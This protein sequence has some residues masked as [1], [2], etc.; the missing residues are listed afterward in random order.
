MGLT[1]QP[2]VRPA[3]IPAALTAVRAGTRVLSTNSN[4]A[5]DTA[6]FSTIRTAIKAFPIRA[7]LTL[8][9]AAVVASCGDGGQGLGDNDQV[10]VTAPITGFGSVIQNGIEWRTSY[11]TG[12]A[13][14]TVD[15][16]PAAEAD[17]RSG[18]IVTIQ[19]LLDS[20]GIGGEAASIA[21]LSNV[22]GVVQSVNVLNGTLVILGQTILT[23]ADT[24]IDASLT[25]SGIG[26]LFPGQHLRVSGYRD[27]VSVIH[28]TRVDV[29]PFG[30][31]VKVLGIVAS[32]NPGTS[33]F[34][35]NGVTVDYGAATLAGYAAGVT[36]AV[37]DLVQASGTA[38]AGGDLLTAATVA[39]ENA[40]APAAQGDVGHIEG[41]VTNASGTSFQVGTVT[42][43]TN[44]A[45]LIEGGQPADLVVGARVGV[46]GLVNVSGEIVASG[47]QIRIPT[48]QALVEIVTDV[49]VID[50][51]QSNLSVFGAP[52]IVVD[53]D[54]LTRYEDQS[55]AELRTFAL[56]D[57][58]VGD[59]LRIRGYVAAGVDR[60]LATRVERQNAST[61]ILLRGPVDDFDAL[62][63]TMTVLGVL[64]PTNA[65]TFFYPDNTT[66]SDITSDQ[67]FA[68]L[69]VGTVVAGE[70]TASGGA[71]L[72]LGAAWI[73]PPGAAGGP[74]E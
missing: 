47:V 74:D 63:G 13:T 49:S 53:V 10:G 45:T 5:E 27:A 59:H 31:P 70:G 62:A 71:V 37:G 22:D 16:E 58:A 28:A 34:T 17:L 51:G 36:P 3:G 61:G 56:A 40:G 12:A 35:I 46:E 44:S 60:V 69:S 2:Y 21:L 19:G 50:V 48:A 7:L 25:G 30:A 73:V 18:Q 52:G 6:I 55:A 41:F 33:T 9:G 42:F 8:V 38:N 14:I 20:N 67:F 68:L 26:A 43:V 64:L 65:G 72:P 66:A 54:E 24:A 29:R 32:P 39:L 57:V 4:N 15:G 23:D 11:P 1:V